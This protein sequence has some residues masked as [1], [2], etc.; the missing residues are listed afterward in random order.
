[1]TEEP[2]KDRYS[3]KDLVAMASS[4]PAKLVE[5]CM[6]PTTN[7]ATRV[8]GLE[9]LACVTDRELTKGVLLHYLRDDASSIFRESALC[10]LSDE[11]KE[12]PE[13]LSRLSKVAHNPS[14]EMCGL[15]CDIIEEVEE[16]S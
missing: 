13:V 3:A 15:A 14:D 8:F 5:V 7:L 10:G 12:N 6:S 1:M 2:I 9:A 4:H 16:D 11:G